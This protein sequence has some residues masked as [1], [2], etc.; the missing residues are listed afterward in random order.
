[1]SQYLSHRTADLILDNDYNASPLT[2]YGNKYS[3][4][5]ESLVWYVNEAARMRG[6]RLKITFHPFGMMTIG[7]AC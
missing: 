4:Y 6:Y 1:M 2:L 5:L 7:K 3:E